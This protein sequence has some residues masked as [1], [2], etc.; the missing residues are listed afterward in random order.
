MFFRNDRATPA[1]WAI[2]FNHD[3]AAAF[4]SV[5]V[6]SVFKATMLQKCTIALQTEAAQVGDDNFRARVYKRLWK[7]VSSTSPVGQPRLCLIHGYGTLGNMGGSFQ[8]GD[9]PS[10]ADRNSKALFASSGVHSLEPSSALAAGH[11]VSPPLHAA[12]YG[13]SMPASAHVGRP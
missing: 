2:Q 1:P 9:A 5:S 4:Q 11:P 13:G 3:R 6:H 10:R 12:V 8:S 7:E